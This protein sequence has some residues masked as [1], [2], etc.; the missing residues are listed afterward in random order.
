MISNLPT[1]TGGDW[2]SVF[3]SSF[4]LIGFIV[5]LL[6]ASKLRRFTHW[7]VSICIGICALFLMS[8]N[9][10]RIQHQLISIFTTGSVFFAFAFGLLPITEQWLTETFYDGRIRFTARSGL[11]VVDHICTFAIIQIYP[12][13]MEQINQS[14]LTAICSLALILGGIYGGILFRTDQPAVTMEEEMSPLLDS[15]DDLVE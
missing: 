12:T 9:M 5:T 7:L 13:L 11:A 3:A 6:F 14:D 8:W 4:L 15:S 10:R 2:E 1:F